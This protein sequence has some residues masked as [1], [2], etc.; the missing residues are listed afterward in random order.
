MIATMGGFG[1]LFVCVIGSCDAVT[2]TI[3]YYR[4]HSLEDFWHVQPASIHCLTLLSS[5][6]FPM[7]CHVWWACLQILLA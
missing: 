4:A 7:C 1:R 3:V 6:T 5:V 2:F